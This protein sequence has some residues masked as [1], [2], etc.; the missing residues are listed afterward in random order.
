MNFELNYGTE[1]ITLSVPD[2]SLEEKR[3]LTPKKSSFIPGQP[4][5]I[6]AANL[7]T[8][9]IRET[10]ANKV[11]AI[12]IND[13]FRSG[14]Q[15]EIL[16]SYLEILSGTSYRELRIFFATGTHDPKV[17]TSNLRAF[18]EKLT[19]DLNLKNVTLYA[20]NCYTQSDYAYLGKTKRNTEVLIYRPLL[21]CGLRLYGHEGKFHYM[22][23]YSSMEKQILPGFSY[24]KTV[25]SNHKLALDNIH[26]FAGRHPWQ[27]DAS[28]QNNP[29]SCDAKEA[30]ELSENFIIDEH[31]NL[32]KRKILTYGVEMVSS[33]DKILWIDSGAIEKI[34]PAMVQA[35]DEAT[36]FEVKPAKYAV[37]SPG[38]PPASTN[39]YGVQNCFDMALKGSIMQGGEALIIAPC[40]GSP[41]QDTS[42]KGLATSEKSKKLF[43]DNLVKMRDWEINRITDWIDKNFELYLWKTD[44]VLK[45]MKED[46]IK[47]YIYTQ[48]LSAE[49]L[50][51][52]GFHLCTDPQK[53]I[54]ERIARNDGKFNVINNGNKILCTAIC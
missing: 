2:N 41:G 27:S 15:K 30:R 18:A 24:F 12:I 28:R 42:F 35:V 7:D 51:A 5:R 3:L 10:A 53:W 17:Y 4:K 25:E 16:Q 47:L 20:N 33:G 23:G 34:E 8:E 38:G 36:R 11:V 46:K 32:V 50:S 21:E 45:L 43:W 1:K 29:F 39:I 9:F 44:R 48:N 26:S 54:E 22:A 40:N 14:L 19:Q 52:A 13:E 31:G 49:T 6:I 37:V